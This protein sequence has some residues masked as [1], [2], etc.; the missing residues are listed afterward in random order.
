[1]TS[2]GGEMGGGRAQRHFIQCV[3][4][5]KMK[6]LPGEGAGE[7]MIKRW[8]GNYFNENGKIINT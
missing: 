7:M 2:V 5:R 1:M 6:L 3:Q 4:M 8:G